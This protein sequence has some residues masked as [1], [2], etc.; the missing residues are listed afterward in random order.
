M[1]RGDEAVFETDGEAVE[2][3]DG[4]AVSREM[5]VEVLGASECFRVEDLGEAVGELLGVGGGFAEGGCDGE[6]CPFGGSELRED[7]G[8]G[9]GD[10]LD[11][12]GRVV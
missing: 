1:G 12:E 4:F 6:G 9:G 5:V 3:A 10:D 2:G 7:V 11:V 8:G